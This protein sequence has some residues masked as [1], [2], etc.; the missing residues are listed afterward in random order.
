[1]EAYTYIIRIIASTLSLLFVT[2]IYAQEEQEEGT[3]E[4]KFTK[5]KDEREKP[6]ITEYKIISF[7][8]DTTYL[9]TTLTIEKDYRFNYL[10]QDN[11]ELVPFSNTGRTYT[12]LA[13]QN[14]PL[15]VMPHFGARARHFNY[16]RI[17]DISFYRVPTPLTELYYKSV[18]EQGQNVDSFFTINTSPNLNF[19]VAYKGLRSLGRFQHILTSTGNLRFTTNFQ[20]PNK[21]YGLRA[22]FL[23]QDQF[24]E[25][26]GGLDGSGLVTYL[27][28]DR[29][30]DD[31]AAL[32]VN[33]ED[34]QTMLR[35]KTFY[36]DHHYDIIRPADSISQG[37]RLFVRHQSHLIDKFYRFEQETASPAFFG[38]SFV[39]NDIHDRTSLEDFTN[40]ASVVFS[41]PWVGTID[42][43]GAYSDYNYGYNRIVR[44]ENQFIPNRIKGNTLSAGGTY[45]H[46]LYGFDFHAD[47]QVIIDSDDFEGN[48]VL[49]RFG[50]RLNPENS[51]H[52][53]AS[54]SDV[55]PNYNFLL[56]QSAYRGYNWRNTFENINTQTLQL[57]LNSK[58]LFDLEATYQ[59]ISNYTYFRRNPE[60]SITTPVQFGQTINVL[61]AKLHRKFTVWRFSLDS[62]IMYQST[63][64]D[65]EDVYNVPELSGRGT[66][67]YSDHL[68]RK[69]LFMQAGVSIKY[70]TSFKTD[71]YDPLLGEFYVASPYELPVEQNDVIDTASD[72]VEVPLTTGG[73]PVI[74]IF[75]NAKVR[76]TRLF[77]KAEH[78]NELFQQNVNFVAPGYPYRDFIIRFGLVWDFFL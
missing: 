55:S 76:Q 8:N 12:S 25:E 38:E 52:L 44:L 42:V 60:D 2:I 70:W 21:K 46:S 10:R 23:A 67:Y 34:A 56:H 22:I 53:Q 16:M 28:G 68:F 1:M 24:N 47:G 50:Y 54:Q 32:S 43:H 77:V 29:E 33:Y 73:F 39:T 37:T 4:R 45:S 27:L 40:T 51:I 71:A 19:S 5:K 17:E 65:T 11:F 20:L 7:A 3:L 78:F 18:F 14:E 31:R 49:G 9:D 48:Y 72:T 62:D 74:D 15:S 64:L 58:L 6:S 63:N 61:K 69:A 30:L 36:F 26:N 75:F 35:G 57:Q 66:F 41:D 59:K 13:K